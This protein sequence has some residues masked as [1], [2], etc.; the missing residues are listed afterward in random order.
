MSLIRVGTIII[1]TLKSFCKY[2]SIQP[3]IRVSTLITTITII[4]GRSYIASKQDKKKYR[5][6][7]TPKLD[8]I[9]MKNKNYIYGKEF[10]SQVKTSFHRVE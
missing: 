7:I 8:K 10:K 6:N 5:E 4:I 1:H 3:L 2:L 9:K